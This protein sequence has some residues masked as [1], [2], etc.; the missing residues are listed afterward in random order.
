MIKILILAS[1]LL[2][3]ITPL[4]LEED[5]M[6]YA[7]M[8]SKNAYLINREG[9]VL[10]KWTS[11]H[12]PGISTYLLEDGSI[13]YTTKLGIAM[14]SGGGVQKWSWD[15]KKLWDFEYYDSI[16]LAHH[17][18]EPLPNG[19]VLMIA[20]EKKSYSQSIQAGC[21][22]ERLTYGSLSPDHIIEVK[23]TGLYTGDIVWEWHVWDHLIQDFDP[24]KDNYGVVADHPE[25]ININY[26]GMLFGD[27]THIN[28][29]DYIEEYDHILL[30]SRHMNEIWIIDHGIT[31]EQAKG[32]AGDLLY[33]WGN[34]EAYDGDGEQQLFFQH[35]AR[36][37]DDD[38]I[39]IYNNGNGRPNPYT[40]I[41]EIIPPVN[42]NGIY[43]TGPEE[44]IWS[45]TMNEYYYY[46][47][48]VQKL[49]NDNYLVCNGQIGE[50]IEV[51]P[52]KNVIW[53]YTN[54]YPSYLRN[55][56]FKVNYYPVSSGESKVDCVGS[57]R[58]KE[59]S[60][61]VRNI[62]EET[63]NWEIIEYPDWG[64]WTFSQ[65]SGTLS[66]DE[67]TIVQVSIDVLSGQ[68][69]QGMV[70]VENEDNPSDFDTVTVYLNLPRVKA[71]S[72]LLEL[73]LWVFR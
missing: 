71:L 35:D 16:V 53:E 31:T 32:S 56:V 26:G 28:S 11:D 51:T 6:L 54:P 65:E 43:G 24:T 5:V 34:P 39:T 36:W 45:Y 4:T 12:Y 55:N 47:G 63:L 18:I 64:E 23:Q 57:I 73:I 66:P 62:G 42:S 61:K 7:P 72:R 50:F 37:T 29:I 8:Q 38:T 68:V 1:L 9:E 30:S 20:W 69:Y 17:D 58:G 48:G 27:W 19:N 10:N 40:T 67:E 14:G 13:L 33:R 70:T 49:P 22:P 21:D 59:S 44:P 15:N 60:F 3:P 2:M 25:L 46:V 52:S 41:D